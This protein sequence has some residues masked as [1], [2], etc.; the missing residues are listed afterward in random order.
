MGV[1]RALPMGVSRALD[2][3]TWYRYSRWKLNSA[4]FLQFF[5]LFSFVPPSPG[6]C[7][8]DALV[9]TV[10][11]CKN[12]IIDTICGNRKPKTPVHNYIIKFMT[13]ICS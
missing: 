4:I 6:K 3:N 1:S 5:A 10:R 11:L 2:F 8:V 9:R 12:R 13:D 7:F